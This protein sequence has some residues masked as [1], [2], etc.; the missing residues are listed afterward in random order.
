MS[1]DTPIVFI[2]DDDVSVRE[3]LELLISFAGWQPETFASAQE[4]LARPR[5]LTPSCLILDISLP[6]LNGLDLQ[7]LVADRIDM[8]I[9]FITGYGDIPM[10]VRAMKAGAVE[11]LTKPFDDEV[12]LGAIR[13]SLERSRAAIVI[14]AEVQALREC[15]ATLTPR[16]QEVMALVASGHLNKQIGFKLGISE[17]TVKAHR[18]KVM[19]KMKA[20]SLAD[21]V[22]MAAKLRLAPRSP[23]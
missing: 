7:K 4:F 15:Y 5:A 8:P 14:E 10:T 23:R 11:F 1:D 2:V 3:S 16:E 9:I 22:K 13:Q 19:Q 18:G 6:D 20:D 17:I 12:I 21:L